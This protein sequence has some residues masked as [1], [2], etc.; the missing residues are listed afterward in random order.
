MVSTDEEDALPHSAG[1]SWALRGN[2]CAIDVKTMAPDNNSRIN[3]RSGFGYD[4]WFS[5]PNRNW[6]FLLCWR[7]SCPCCHGCCRCYG[8]SRR[9][10]IRFHHRHRHV[11]AHCYSTYA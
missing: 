5:A 4:S 1:K 7:S 3:S 6:R 9:F 8:R 11:A 10:H 2:A